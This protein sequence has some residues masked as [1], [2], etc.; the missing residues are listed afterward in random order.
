M[1]TVNATNE[2]LRGMGNNLEVRED[3][4]YYFMNRIWVPKLGGFRE[5]VMNEA[6]K[7]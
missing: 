6:H 2:M 1:K 4:A 7:M 5:I 3:R